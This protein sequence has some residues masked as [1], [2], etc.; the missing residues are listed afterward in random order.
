MK[1]W[2]KRLFKLIFVIF[3][4]GFIFSAILYY[5]GNDVSEFSK[6]KIVVIDLQDVIYESDTIINKLKKYNK[7]EKVK[8]F[9]LRVNSPGGGVAPSQ[10]IYRYIKNLDK[11][12]FVA[13]QSLA[14]SGGYYVSIA[15]DKI[16]ALPGTIT[17]SI[18]VIIKFPNMKGLYE[19]IG[20]DFQT[21][22]SG[23]FKDIGSPNREMTKEEIKLLQDS[24]ME[25]YNQFVNDILSSRKIK[26]ETLLAY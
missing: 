20:I 26:K 23:K 1:K 17:G 5:T 22:K 18:G 10:E 3:I 11:P 19:K 21:I 8:G 6:N 9:I 14:A 13:M 7:N 25:V 4:V 15:A 12:V 24:I 2:G 16:Y